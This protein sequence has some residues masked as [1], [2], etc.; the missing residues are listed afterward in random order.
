MRTIIMTL[1]L[2]LAVAA[3]VSP[4]RNRGF[5][6]PASYDQGAEESRG[7]PPGPR[8]WTT[9]NDPALNALIGEA[10]AAN[11]TVA[12]GIERVAQARAGLRIAGATLVPDAGASGS[13]GLDINNGDFSAS[14]R[15]NVSYELDLF[16]RNRAELAGARASW[17]GSVHNQHAL[18]LTVQAEVAATWFSI[19][20]LDERLAV[21]R[22]SL[23]AAEKILDLIE[24]RHRAGAASGFDLSRQRSAVAGSR[25]GIVGLEE[26]RIR[27]VNAL[28]IL[29][30]GPPEE[31][32]PPRADFHALTLPRIDPGLPSSLLL[33]RP[34]ILSAEAALDGADADIRAAR[35]AFFPQID[36]GAALTGA[37]LTSGATLLGDASASLFMTIFSGGRLEGGLQRAK[38]RQRELVANYRQSIL[39]ALGEVENAL[40]AVRSSTLQAEQQEIA[41][42]EAERAARLS[43]IRYEAGADDL[44]AVLDAQ[45]S[46]LSAADSLVQARLDRLTAAVNLFRALG[47][48]WE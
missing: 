41:T 36:L 15:L 31:F 18:V 24:R 23:V 29:L 20:A 39:D 46:E 34:D 28:A 4:S 33:R 17:R 11:N 32:E 12:A 19:L 44:L 40:A 43:E 14:A 25:A 22:R 5:E 7:A 13:G 38:A 42:R 30:G 6:M 37:S 47:G 16:G 3:C 35:A 45:R 27:T 10:M 21:A 9:F 48:G 26:Q 2:V 1:I 8:W